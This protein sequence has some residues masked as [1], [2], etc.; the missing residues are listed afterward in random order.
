MRN[1]VLG[2][3]AIVCALA[4]P[5]CSTTPTGTANTCMSPATAMQ[6]A[7]CAASAYEPV[8]I[9]ALDYV[10]LPLCEDGVIY[11]SCA[12]RDAVQKIDA[13]N[14]HAIAALMVLRSAAIYS[15]TAP[16]SSVY[17]QDDQVTVAL[18][19]LRKSLPTLFPPP[20]PRRD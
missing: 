5:G 11:P 3:F 16:A 2:G 19:A 12:D 17:A 4:L 18:D 14:R 10:T 8:Q 13:A 7:D 6:V 20:A 1:S 9:Q 15:P